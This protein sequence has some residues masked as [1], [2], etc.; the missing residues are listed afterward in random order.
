MGVGVYH[1]DCPVTHLAHVL[2]WHGGAVAL[3]ALVGLG[4]G[5]GLERLE[6]R[7][8]SRRLAER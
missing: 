8:M 7:R 6:E 4:L 3:L 1:L 2:V 5:L